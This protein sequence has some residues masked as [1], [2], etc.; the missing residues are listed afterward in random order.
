MDHIKPP[1]Q[2]VAEVDKTTIQ[3]GTL[4]A[5][6]KHETIG[7]SSCIKAIRLARRA[8]KYYQHKNDDK[9]IVS[10]N[11]NSNVNEIEMS[12]FVDGLPYGYDTAFGYTTLIDPKQK[13]K[14]LAE[15]SNAKDFKDT[16]DFGLNKA[17]QKSIDLL[18]EGMLKIFSLFFSSKMF[19]Y[20]LTLFC[21]LNYNIKIT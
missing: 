17:E 2:Y 20:R 11:S 10:I 7:N 19:E 9:K 6:T 13:L 3:R 4:K 5:D 12:D 18:I 8:T 21:A 14:E 1:S 15:S 16:E